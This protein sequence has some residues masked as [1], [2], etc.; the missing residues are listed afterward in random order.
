MPCPRA[1]CSPAASG[2]LEITAQTSAGQAC[3]RQACTR[4]CIVLPRPDIRMTRRHEEGEDSGKM[5]YSKGEPTQNCKLLVVKTSLHIYR[6]AP[7]PAQRMPC[8]L[9]IGNF[10]EIGRASCR[11][12]VCHYV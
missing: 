2:R 7:P 11:E 12:R 4:A 6:S 3:S 10:D 8:A 5:R 1:H 9:T